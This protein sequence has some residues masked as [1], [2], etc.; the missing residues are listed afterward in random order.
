MNLPV[1]RYWRNTKKKNPV[2]YD[3]WRYD[4]ICC[5]EANVENGKS[6]PYHLT[7]VNFYDTL[8]AVR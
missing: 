1:L 5:Y 8:L 2:N 4:V 3:M 7:S 6:K